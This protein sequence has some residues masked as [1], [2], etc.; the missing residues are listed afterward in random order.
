MAFYELKSKINSLEEELSK[1]KDENL[2]L[3]DER[4]NAESNESKYRKKYN[5]AKEN[6]TKMTKRSA[7]IQNQ[8]LLVNVEHD[9]LKEE[10]S[11]LEE[12]YASDLERCEKIIKSLKVEIYESRKKLKT[13]AQ[14]DRAIEQN[15]M[16]LESYR[17]QLAEK[18]KTDKLRETLLRVNFQ[19]QIRDALLLG[20][21]QGREAERM[22]QKKKDEENWKKLKMLEDEEL[23]MEKEARMSAAH[24]V[25]SELNGHVDSSVLRQNKKCHNQDLRIKPNA[26]NAI[27]YMDKF[28]EHMET[29]NK[30]IRKSSK[31][32]PTGRI[33]A[34]DTGK[35]FESIVSRLKNMNTLYAKQQ[36]RHHPEEKKMTFKEIQ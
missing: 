13:Y 32:D 29:A 5:R 17:I 35:E 36:N 16:M 30:L 31:S 24:V 33:D 14:I 26:S 23:M 11:S 20:Q 10:H 18:Q 2:R 22:R 9:K 8:L 3:I 28:N 25:A 7:E 1:V 6:L 15:K 12:E 34:E 27:F 21:E 4:Q 19:H